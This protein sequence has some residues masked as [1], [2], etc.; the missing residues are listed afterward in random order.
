[1]LFITWSGEVEPAW[2]MLI[3]MPAVR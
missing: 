2:T 1:V 3:G